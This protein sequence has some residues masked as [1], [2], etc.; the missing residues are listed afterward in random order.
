MHFSLVGQNMF[1]NPSKLL[2]GYFRIVRKSKKRRTT[3]RENFFTPKFMWNYFSP[4][5]RISLLFFSLSSIDFAYSSFIIIFESFCRFELFL[6][7][8]EMS[9]RERAD[10][11]P[12][13]VKKVIMI[14]YLFVWNNKFSIAGFWLLLGILK[15]NCRMMIQK[16]AHRVTQ[17]HTHKMT[18]NKYLTLSGGEKFITFLILSVFAESKIII[19]FH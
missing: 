16:A 10:P 19:I 14:I 7:F 4:Q 8:F 6:P 2:W 3:T 5:Q 17:F 11:N 1:W 15:R 12:D 13:N 18:A 9:Q